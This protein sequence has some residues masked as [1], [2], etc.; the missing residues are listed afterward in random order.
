M[1]DS[2]AREGYNLIR[3]HGGC[4]GIGVL[5]VRI[6]RRVLLDLG[7]AVL[8]N[9]RGC[10]ASEEGSE[11]S[12][13]I[14]LATFTVLVFGCLAWAADE[15]YT[16][17]VSDS[18]CAAKHATASDAAATCVEKCV[19]GGAKYVLV[20]KGKVYQ[21]DPQDKFQGMGGKAVKVMGSLT[22]DTLAVSSVSGAEGK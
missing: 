1:T 5:T 17:T 11:M 14:V 20:S 3:C 6:P 7:V 9:L 8:G 2:R 10:L 13:R 15:T 21:L 18:H 22:G 16:G 12:K 4:L 19:S